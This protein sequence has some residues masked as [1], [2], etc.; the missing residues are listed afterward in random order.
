M[1]LKCGIVGLPNVG[2]ST[3]FNALTE[4]KAPAEAYPFCTINPNIANVEVPDSRLEKLA[5]LVDSKRIIPA[6]VE[7]VDIAGLVPGASKGEG[8][9]N[10][11]LSHIRQIDLVIH[12][13][14]FFKDMSVPHFA[15][16][17]SPMCDIETIETELILSDL[18]ISER[19][20]LHYIK[21]EKSG[22][23]QAKHYVKLLKN[24]YEQLNSG[25][26]I[27]TSKFLSEDNYFFLSSLFITAKPILYVANICD[28]TD[29]SLN[30]LINFA[31][32]RDSSVIQICA[33]KFAN[34][35]IEKNLE[36]VVLDHLIQSAFKLLQLQTYFTVGNKEIRAWTIPVGTK[37]PRAAGVIHS[38]FER[39]FIR[40]KTIAYK[41][42]I[43]CNG[44]QGAKKSG[45]VRLE[46]KNYVVQDGDIMNFLFSV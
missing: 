5:S 36:K 8:L 44:E 24:C 23:I 42:F 11:F 6:S 22:N 16:R 10:Q 1:S 14:R 2:K 13:A 12:V 3:L 39:G 17:Y 35:N 28:D 4:S 9:G 27:R 18:Q 15:E 7:F 31:Q 20:L 45:K 19:N 46:G 30:D 37:A 26:L 43:E 25:K 29:H 34:N 38:D 41:D 33:L 21:L 32:S 40:A